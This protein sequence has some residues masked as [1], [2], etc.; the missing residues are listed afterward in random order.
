MADS[1][2]RVSARTVIIAT[3]AEYR[4]LPIDNLSKF[5][6][7][8]VYYLATPMEAQL[9]KDE[10]VMLVGGGNSAVRTGLVS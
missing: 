1:G 7:A 2:A 6:G 3:G 10:K 4:G 9:C 8:G 5:N